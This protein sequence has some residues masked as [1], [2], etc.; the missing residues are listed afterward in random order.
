MEST[1]LLVVVI[2]VII[3]IKEI[4]ARKKNKADLSMYR[5]KERLMNDSEQA[6][7]INLQKSL[8]DE[9]LVLSKVRIEDFVEVDKSMAL[10]YRNAWSLRGRIK[11]RHVDFLICDFATTKPILAIELDGKSH[12]N[13]A[14][15][16]RDKFVNELYSTI[17][18]PVKHV[19]VGDNFL[20]LSQE[21][22]EII[23]V[24]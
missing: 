4:I 10:N 18:L 19:N 15:Q 22:K 6:L 9:C 11:S 21:I 7:F 14:R 5:K 13:S 24:K 17:G 16:D 1:I 3:F 2:I 20:E 12:L 23:S 8:G